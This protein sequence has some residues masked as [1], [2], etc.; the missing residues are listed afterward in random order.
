[1]ALLFWPTLVTF[2]G[3]WSADGFSHSWLV[4]ALT[5]WLIWW[6]RDELAPS[7]GRG[8]PAL[9][10]PLLALSVLWLVAIIANLRAVHQ[11]T[12]VLLL[13]GW[14]LVTAGPRSART[15]VPIAATFM[16]AVPIWGPLVPVLREVTVV[17]SGVLLTVLRVPAEID[18]DRILIEAGSFIVA[19]GCAG[20]NYLLAGLVVGA[21]YAH[22][23]VTGLGARLAVV[24]LAAALAIIGN[25]V[26][27]AAI[28][29]IGY[30]SQM[31]S[32]MVEDHL[33]LGWVIFSIGLVP[34]FFFAGRIAGKD[35]ASPLTT[36]PS[37]AAAR[38]P[39]DRSDDSE[40]VTPNRRAAVATAIALVGPVLYVSVGLLPDSASAESGASAFTPSESWSAIPAGSPRPFAWQPAYEGASEQHA[41]AFSDGY[42]DVYVDRLL[43]REQT[44]GAEMI[45]FPNRIAA[46]AQLIDE[47]VGRA[48]GDA[49]R[50]L[51]QA[52]VRT[53]E[54]PI[55]VWYWFRIGGVDTFSPIRAKLLEIRAFVLRK[56][57]SELI[58]VSAVCAV[59]DCAEAASHLSSFLQ[60]QQKTASDPRNTP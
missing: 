52:I 31:Q 36:R 45:G 34:F 26:R 18:G 30:L 27:V 48:P 25:W 37:K 17:A 24:G 51:R 15:I 22:L 14:A 4:A 33:W 56:P 60:E 38:E 19:N 59:D 39:E 28:V 47:I 6:H 50:W 20:L 40:P 7:A 54:A 1:M 12:L 3:V 21:A 43:Y 35:G 49:G 42:A 46:E 16:L 53:P 57:T 5:V 23:V 29:I 8:D 2:P 41:S 9:L 44:G 10:L 13:T 11:A 58:S 32:G 55:L